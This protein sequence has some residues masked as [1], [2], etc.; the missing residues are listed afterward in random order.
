MKL[1]FEKGNYC[2]SRKAWNAKRAEILARAENKCEECGVKNHAVGYRNTAGK[3][4]R[5]GGNSHLDKAGFGE[6]TLKEAREIAKNGYDLFGDDG[7]FVVVL[8]I[9]HTNHN[10]QNNDNSNL[11][12]LCCRC[13]NLHDVEYRKT[14]RAK[15]AR[16]NKKLDNDLFL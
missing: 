8:T 6:L 1:T 5:L 9:S 3:F 11:R 14:N 2:G 12:A 4:I 13:H 7:F 16:K 15:T 10:T